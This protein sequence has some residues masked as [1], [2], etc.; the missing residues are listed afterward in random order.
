MK[1]GVIGVLKSSN[2]S[3]SHNIAIRAEL[4]GLP[5][6]EQEKKQGETISYK[7]THPGHMH[8]CGHDGHMAIVLGIAE[9]F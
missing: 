7:S 1:T 4:D 8:A 2:N 5:I 6:Q 3:N 9:Y